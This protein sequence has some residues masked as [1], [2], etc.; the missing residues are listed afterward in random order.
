MDFYYIGVTNLLGV[1]EFGLNAGDVS[2][3]DY[4]S[5]I[6]KSSSYYSF[7]YSYLIYYA[8]YLFDDL[9]CV[10]IYSYTITFF[11]KLFPSSIPMLAGVLSFLN[12]PISILASP[13]F[14][15]SKEYNNL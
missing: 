1:L 12:I 13:S 2:Y 8:F 4:T 6:V 10:Y 11:Y 7:I 14:D 3:L 5:S 9:F 15:I